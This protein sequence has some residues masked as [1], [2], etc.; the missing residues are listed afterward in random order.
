M[1]R[2]QSCDLRNPHKF[3][4]P[5]Q[6]H[7]IVSGME[8]QSSLRYEA[9]ELLLRH[10]YDCHGYPNGVDYFRGDIA[11]ELFTCRFSTRIEKYKGF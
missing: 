9:F 10:D 2:W 1:L 5:K 6:G 7:S 8:A 3:P 4:L 11:K